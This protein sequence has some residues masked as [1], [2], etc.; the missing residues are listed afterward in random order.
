LTGVNRI[1]LN[2]VLLASSVVVIR[3]CLYC[4]MY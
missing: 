1:S 3:D 2:A 4:L